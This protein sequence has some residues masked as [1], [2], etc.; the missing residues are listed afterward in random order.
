MQI[1]QISSLG[2][3]GLK[4]SEEPQDII[5]VDFREQMLIHNDID[6]ILNFDI[7]RENNCRTYEY[8]TSGMEP[9]QM[10]C[11]RRR[12]CHDDITEILGGIL[13]TVY[14]AREFMLVEDDYVIRPDTVF[15]ES[16]TKVRVAYFPGYKVSLRQQLCELSEYLM[17]RIEYKD[18]GAVLVVYSFYSKT[19]NE[20]CSLEDLFE[21][22]TGKNEEEEEATRLPAVPEKALPLQE[23]NLP[24]NDQTAFREIVPDNRFVPPSAVEVFRQSPSRLRYCA[25]L[26]PLATV[27]AAIAFLK[28]DL[29]RNPATGKPFVLASFGC[30]FVA[31]CLTVGLERTVWKRFYNKLVNSLKAASAECDDATVMVYA[32]GTVAYPFSLVSD[33]F[34]AI[35]ASRFPFVIGKARE[36][37]D[38][39][40][41]KVGVSRQHL[42][43]DRTEGGFSVTDLGS[44]NGTWVNS[45]RLRPGVSVNVRCGD[46]IRIGTYI[47]YCNR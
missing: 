40:L 12:L 13:R 20:N 28:S 34:E 14:R 26:I 43:I 1:E 23:H 27:L 5:A 4:I 21:V 3:Q 11:T 42:R 29:L 39:C 18:E 7:S 22:L 17:D 44:T 10:I 16:G 37:S 9:L 19:R 47:F 36:T 35:N 24:V 41:D 45:V 2:R 30:V 15:L 32:N 46:E 33:E 6:G 31:L 25:V 38:Y 8:S